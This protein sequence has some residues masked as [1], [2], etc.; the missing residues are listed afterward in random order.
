[1][2]NVQ[3]CRKVLIYIPEGRPIECEVQQLELAQS[4]S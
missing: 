2:Q 4:A 3:I 1:M